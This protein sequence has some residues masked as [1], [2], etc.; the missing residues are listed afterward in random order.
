TAESAVATAARVSVAVPGSKKLDARIIGTDPVTALTLLRID[1]PNLRSLQLPSGGTPLESGTGVVVMSA[2]R[3]LALRVGAISATGVSVLADDLARPGQKRP[4][5][6]LVSLDV[7]GQSG[8][9]GAPILDG[10]GRLVGVVIAT[11][12]SVLG[13]DLGESQPALQQLMLSGHVTYP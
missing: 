8:Q 1:A 2:T 6:D 4:L 7:S 10:G 11:G 9:L 13:A 5:N 12:D 3:G